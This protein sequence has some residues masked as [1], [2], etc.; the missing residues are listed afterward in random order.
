MSRNPF[1]G[2]ETMRDEIKSNF[3]GQHSSYAVDTRH[4]QFRIEQ[5]SGLLGTLLY[6]CIVTPAGS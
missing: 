1:T 5:Q 4:I 6:F 2:S 3:D